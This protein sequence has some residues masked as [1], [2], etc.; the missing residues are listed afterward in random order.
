MRKLFFALTLVSV[1]GFS[2]ASCRADETKVTFDSS[3]S[4]TAP[5]G[6][7]TV[8]AEVWG[9]G[10]AGGWSDGN[11]VTHALGGGGGGG[12]GGYGKGTFSVTPGNVYTVKVG[13]GGS[14]FGGNSVL[15][16]GGDGG[17]S[18]FA[19]FVSATGGRGGCGG[20]PPAGVETQNTECPRPFGGAGGTSSAPISILG[21]SGGSGGISGSSVS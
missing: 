2:A 14:A 9:A 17:T 11:S 18:S 21:G 10:G 4:W 1:L 3:G 12:G 5:P 13:S 6:I 20:G 7:S 19:S 16:S 8:T 15:L